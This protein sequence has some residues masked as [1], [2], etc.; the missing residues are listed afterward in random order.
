MTHARCLSRLRCVATAGLLC[1]LLVA[2]PALARDP[3]DGTVAM[4]G[5][6][7]IPDSTASAISITRGGSDS[8]GLTLG[9]FGLP[10]TVAESFP[11]YLEG[12]LG[13][14]RYDPRFVASGGE[15][16]RARLARMNQVTGTVGVGWD[17]RLT[18]ELV[19]RPIANGVLGVVATD[20]AL[21][22]GLINHRRDTELAIV[23][24]GSSVATGWGGSL[25]LDYTRYRASYE[26]D[27]EL[28]YSALSFAATERTPQGGRGEANSQ[29][30]GLWARLRWPT[31][32]ELIGRPVRY[33]VE[34]AHSQFFGDQANVLGFD[35]L[36]KVGG[37]L[38]LDVGRTESTLLG[39]LYLERIRLVGR[40]VFGNNVSGFSVGLGFGF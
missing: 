1:A 38:E 3:A 6:T 11:L 21:F 7:A 40:Y 20:P 19:L 24:G 28:R 2:A 18:D 16:S 15:S 4:L 17:V 32:I 9:Q 25:M 35:R 8:L 36:T 31:G 26:L 5:V 10:F 12:F 37:G 13:Y 14:A 39:F 27:V 33:V 30:L 23:E 34:V 22:G 29:T